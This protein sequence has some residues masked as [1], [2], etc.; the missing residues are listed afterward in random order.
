MRDRERRQEIFI[1]SALE[2]NR[3]QKDVHLLIT[4]H[5]SAFSK[6][7]NLQLVCLSRCQ[8]M[9]GLATYKVILYSLRRSALGGGTKYM[10]ETP[11]E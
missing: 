3:A 6:E 9:T 4:C 7:N 8:D 1:R 10:S 11:V 5:V 2:W